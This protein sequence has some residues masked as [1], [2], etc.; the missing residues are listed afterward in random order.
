[1]F[2]ILAAFAIHNHIVDTIASV[3]LGLSHIY[4]NLMIKVCYCHLKHNHLMRRPGALERS[5]W[6]MVEN[7]QSFLGIDERLCVV[8]SW[9]GGDELEI[10]M[11][12][13]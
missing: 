6:I 5:E 4:I 9:N 1:M 12:S 2:K 10:L 13:G 7:N 3:V 8:L 11:T